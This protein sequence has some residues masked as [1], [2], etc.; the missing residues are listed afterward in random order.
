MTYFLF[1][2]CWFQIKH[3]LS[4]IPK[5]NSQIWRFGPKSINF[6]IL[7]KLCEIYLNSW[8][9]VISIITLEQKFTIVLIMGRNQSTLGEILLRCWCQVGSFFVIISLNRLNNRITVQAFLEL[10]FVNYNVELHNVFGQ[11]KLFRILV[12]S[13]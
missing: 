2:R 13:T 9:V 1:R 7:I 8:M 10:K 11:D 3:S 6:Q 4:K 12:L 5:P